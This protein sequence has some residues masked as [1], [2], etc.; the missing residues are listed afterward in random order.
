MAGRVETITSVGVDVGT[1]TT[2]TVVSRLR[3]E[4]SQ[5]D[6]A[7]APRIVD[8]EIVFRGPIHETPLLD[9]ETVDIEGVVELVEGDL[10]EAG[11]S[12]DVVD[13]GAVI[14]TGETARKENAEPLAHRLAADSGTFVAA[15]AGASLE[16]VL[17][18]Q[19]SGAVAHATRAGETVANVDVGGGTTNVAIFEGSEVRETRCLDVGGRLVRFDS[20]EIVTGVSG[21]AR[22]LAEG[23]GITLSVG[24]PMDDGVRR[25]LADAMADSIADLLS[26]PSFDEI[27]RALAIGD[28][29]R[30]R[31]EIDALAFTGGVGRLVRSNPEDLL[32]YGDLGPDLARAIRD[33]P[34]IAGWRRLD[35]AED[36]RATVIG[37]GTETTTF[38]GRTVAVDPAHLPLWNVPVV[39]VGD[40]SEDDHEGELRSAF[41]EAVER[42]RELYDLSDLDALALS[43]DDLGA[44]GYDRIQAAGTA[45]A[46]A[47]PSLPSDLVPVVVTR[48]NCAKA[49]AG[50]AHSADVDDRPLLAI[51]E[52]RV[53]AGDY[54]DIAEPFRGGEAVPVVVKT[55]AFDEGSEGNG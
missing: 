46:E 11:V 37:A 38:S 2:Q 41:E 22:R 50:A 12:S 1:T 23:V 16:A 29:P 27:T 18:A 42:A 3:V 54:L 35:L 8:R 45:L 55:L 7:A 15:V 4:V 48:Q 51:D 43:I 21:P 17:A 5:Y 24:E 10:E 26:G 34:T 47:L 32:A 31:I 25:A 39:S 13:T 52:L 14:V 33:H 28:L 49:L 30:E 19:G 40:L 44:L 6:G 36:I 53:G 20:Q 9:P